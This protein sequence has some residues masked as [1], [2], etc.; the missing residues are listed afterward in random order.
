[1]SE[2][3][4]EQ[5]KS[6]GYWKV[7]IRPERFDR[8]R[9]STLSKCEQL[10][11]ANEVRYRGWYFPHI[12]R[13]DILRGIDYVGLE[14]TFMAINET[15]RFYQS[16]QFALFRGLQ[17]DWVSGSEGRRQPSL[18]PESEKGLDILSALY[19]LSEVYEFAARLAQGGVFDKSVFI[20]VNLV[21]TL[22]RQLFFWPGTGRGLRRHYVCRVSSLP[23]EGVFEVV[24]LIARSR[25]FS[26][27]HFLWL[28][29]RFGFD[30]SPMVFKPDQEKFF[31][32]RY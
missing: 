27:E 4:L 22:N 23:R 32:G 17:E 10:L 30:A 28:M 1:M 20:E 26:F 29:A 2:G 6:R 25:E 13:P 9:I 12:F 24:D 31:E 14:A 5:I 16:G 8:E 21:H 3:V 19:Q 11:E 15:W 18:G 7:V